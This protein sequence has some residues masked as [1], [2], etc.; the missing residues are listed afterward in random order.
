MGWKNELS[1]TCPT[2]RTRASSSTWSLPDACR[3]PPYPQGRQG[4][5]DPRELRFVHGREGRRLEG[6]KLHFK[7]SF[8]RVVP[9]F[10]SRAGMV[11]PDALDPMNGAGQT[12]ITSPKRTPTGSLIA[13]T[14]LRHAARAISMANQGPNT[15][16]ASS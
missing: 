5:E 6:R 15:N 14:I 7:G 3:P 8:H 12:S 16:G 11:H 4:A 13:S 10:C 1:R 2:T 9:T